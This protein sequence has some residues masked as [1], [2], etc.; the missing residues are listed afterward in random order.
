MNLKDASHLSGTLV[1]SQLMKSSSYQFI[2]GKDMPLIFAKSLQARELVLTVRA[3]S[4]N[5]RGRS[6]VSALVW[7][8]FGE[9]SNA[10]CAPPTVAVGV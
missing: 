8:K 2:L 10:S 1:A 7:S 5:C 6:L 9:T 4:K 3:E